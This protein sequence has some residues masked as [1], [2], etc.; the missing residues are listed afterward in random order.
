MGKENEIPEELQE[1]IK[2]AQEEEK[3]VE[4][5]REDFFLEV[6]DA[7]DFHAHNFKIA[8][9]NMQK[10]INLVEKSNSFESDPDFKVTYLRF[11]DG[12]LGLAVEPK[13]EMGFKLPDERKD[14]EGAE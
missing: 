2:Q 6:S 3:P 11:P 8:Q 12:R 9:D 10:A 14:G 1:F 13:G 7:F 4:L 5:T